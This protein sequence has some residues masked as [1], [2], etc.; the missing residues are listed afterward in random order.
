MKSTTRKSMDAKLQ[1]RRT[2]LEFWIA[3]LVFVTY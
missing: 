1:P 2:D 3:V